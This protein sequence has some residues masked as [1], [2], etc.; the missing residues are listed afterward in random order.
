MEKETDF[1]TDMERIF[2]ERWKESERRYH[3]EILKR[4]SLEGDILTLREIIRK[5]KYETKI[6]QE[7]QSCLPR[8]SC[9]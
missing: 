6:V 9:I 2:F 4:V 5:R 3:R 7:T 8:H 1:N